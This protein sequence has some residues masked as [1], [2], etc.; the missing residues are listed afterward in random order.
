MRGSTGNEKVNITTYST[1]VKRHT[2][3]MIT[4]M[5]INLKYKTNGQISRN[6]SYQ[7]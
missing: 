7:K 1:D 4:L 2:I 6:I 5:P 3:T